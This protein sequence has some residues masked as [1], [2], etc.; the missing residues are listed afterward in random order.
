MATRLYVSTME[1]SFFKV[2]S[3]GYDNNPP[4]EGF[5]R[6]GDIVISN[7][8]DVF[9][10][11]CVEEGEPG[12]WKEICDITSIKEDIE[13]LKNQVNKN[14]EDI[15]E[16]QTLVDINIGDIENLESNVETNTGDIIEIQEGMNIHTN[17][18]T[19]LQ[20]Q[21][22]TIHEVILNL[23]NESGT[24]LEDIFNLSEAIGKN[25]TNITNINIDIDE[26]IKPDIE[27]LKSKVESN[28][29]RIEVL[30]DRVDNHDSMIN[31]LNN[32]VIKVETNL[33]DLLKD[34]ENGLIGGGGS[35]GSKLA[36]INASVFIDT[37]TNEVS[38]D[39]LGVLV[40]K[41]NKLTV[42]LN[43]AHLMENVD[44]RIDYENNKIVKITEGKWNESS[45]S[46]SMFAFEL[47]KNV[48]NTDGNNVV[49]KNKLVS[50]TNT[51]NILKGVS[52]VEIGIEGF[53]KD[54]DMLMVFKNS[55]FIVN[56]IE[57][58]ISDDSSK[59]IK[60]DG[61]WNENGLEEYTI[62]FVVFKEV[63]IVDND[64]L[65]N[66]VVNPN[67]L[68][69]YNTVEFND[70]RNSIE[71]GIE[72]FIQ[73]KDILEVHYNGLL[74]V[75]GIHY[76]I[77][78]N[79][80]SIECIGDPW[81]KDAE[82]TQ[83]MTFRVLKIEGIAIQELNNI[84]NID[85]AT[86]EVEIGID[87]FNADSDVIE[88]HLNGVMLVKGLDFN[89]NN[90]KLVKIDKSEPW[91]IYNVQGQKM[92]IKVLKNSSS[93]SNDSKQG[94]VNALVNKGIDVSINT[95]WEDLFSYLL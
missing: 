18:I 73:G 31:D 95:S 86:T 77:I 55:T 84:I 7:N 41:N 1:A 50:A 64:G 67:I 44:Y 90:G 45:I 57:Y 78:N 89:I 5:H 54:T 21:V 23:K 22:G 9:G 38:L 75:E 51:V 88:V 69:Y 93:R 25:T 79:G 29:E 4:I 49:L 52:E 26:N 19:D 72:Q 34:I 40:T 37:P 12:T 71:I 28:T 43:S 35:G 85:T 11:V 8:Q 17:N 82:D 39:S 94:L 87:E 30:E 2:N 20:S 74:L 46:G 58:I 3:M 48:E 10:W 6:V 15:D 66:N 80:L 14:T 16:L 68:G 65:V 13:D 36:S 59:I 32:K 62:T 81:N 33:N 56:D 76:N 70:S 83:Q 47:L 53:D 63:A 91:N 42:H 60:I 24:T 27:D 92:F 61:K